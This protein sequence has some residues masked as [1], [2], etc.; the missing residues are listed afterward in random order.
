MLSTWFKASCTVYLSIFSADDL[1]I[2]N[3]IE[4]INATDGSVAHAVL[5][6]WKNPEWSLPLSRSIAFFKVE[7]REGDSGEFETILDEISTKIQDLENIYEDSDG[8][9]VFRG[10]TKINQSRVLLP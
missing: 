6:S 7:R 10:R 2:V 5:V 1:T 3:P 4:E 8:L 9:Y